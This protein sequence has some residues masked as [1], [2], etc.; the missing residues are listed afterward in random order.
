MSLE[1]LDYLYTVN[2]RRWGQKA[3]KKYFADF[4]KQKIIFLILYSKKSNFFKI[5]IIWNIEFLME[6]YKIYSHAFFKKINEK[7]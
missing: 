7:F 2:Y 4:L 1:Q 3:L 6:K 5:F